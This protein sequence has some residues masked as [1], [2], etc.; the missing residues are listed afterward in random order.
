MGLLEEKV[1]RALRVLET[2]EGVTGKKEGLCRVL[3]R[4]G[5]EAFWEA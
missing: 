5:R 2:E 3:G 4:K 1:R